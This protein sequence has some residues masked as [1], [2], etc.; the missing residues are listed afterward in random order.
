MNVIMFKLM[1]V[2]VFMNES[3]LV[4]AT[5]DENAHGCVHDRVRDHSCERACV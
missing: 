4:F 5:V 1:F 2:H 3:T